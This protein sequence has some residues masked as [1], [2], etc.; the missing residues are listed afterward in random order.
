MLAHMQRCSPMD[1]AG[2]DVVKA[3]TLILC[4]RIIQI[5]RGSETRSENSASSNAVRDLTDRDA[6]EAHP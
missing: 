6:H 3:S 5:S 4:N 2:S 1:F